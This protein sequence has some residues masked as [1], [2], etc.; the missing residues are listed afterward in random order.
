MNDTQAHH[1]RHTHRAISALLALSMLSAPQ[2][3]RASADVRQMPKRYTATVRG[4]MRLVGNTLL[5]CK[6]TPGY[7]ASCSGAQN[8]SGDG[9]N[10]K[11]NM[12]YVDVDGDPA[13]FNASRATLE[14]PNGAQ[15]AFAGLYWGGNLTAGIN[16]QSAPAPA[17]ATSVLLKAPGGAYVPISGVLVGTDETTG[18]SRTYAAFADVTALVRQSG[19]YWVGN[20]QAGTGVRDDAGASGGLFA[21]WGLVVVYR[22]NRLPLRSFNVWDAYFRVAE[23]T[24]G[25]VRVD[26]FITPLNGQF[27][28]QIGTIVFEGDRGLP[29]DSLRLESSLISNGLSSQ[30]N[31]FNGTVSAL[32]AEVPRFPAYVNQL[33]IDVDTFD[34]SAVLANGATTAQITLPTTADNYFPTMIAFAID[35]FEPRLEMSKTFV[36]VNGGAVNPG[37]TLRYTVMMTNTGVDA[38]TRVVLDDAIPANTTYLPGSLRV[39]ENPGSDTGAKT[40]ATGDDTA[41]FNAAGNRVAFRLG[42]G[43]NAQQGGWVAAGTRAAVE[44]CVT[45]NP[46]ASDGTTVLNTAVTTYSGSVISA[47]WSLTASASVDTIVRIPDLSIKISDGG[48]TTAPDGVIVYRITARNESGYTPAENVIV[49]NTLPTYTRY[50]GLETLWRQV[51]GTR[52]YTRSLGRMAQYDTRVLTFPVR[53]DATLPYSLTQLDAIARIGDASLPVPEPNLAN[54]VSTDQTPVE[55]ADIDALKSDALSSVRVGETVQYVFTVTN[56]GPGAAK[57]VRIHDPLYK[58]MLQPVWT[59]SAGPGSACGAAAGSGVISTTA[60]IAANSLVVYRL[61]VLVGSCDGLLINRASAFAP[62]IVDPNPANNIAIDV[63]NDGDGANLYSNATWAAITPGEATTL[64]LTVVN[65]GPDVASNVSMTAR[66]PAGMLLNSTVITGTPA[67][68]RFDAASGRWSIGTM[69]V[70]DAVTLT[71]GFAVTDTLAVGTV[72]TTVIDLDSPS[73]GNAPLRDYINAPV[74]AIVVVAGPQLTQYYLPLAVNR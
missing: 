34:A 36:D 71:L 55:Y 31:V 52:D 14:V 29:G 13:T 17:N 74:E 12:V 27:R 61:S 10:D 65:Y 57:A 68:T 16:G 6:Q 38:A 33:G 53:V 60:D 37:D 45:I 42:A 62:G 2:L 69:A 5:T 43:S 22:D 49:T 24:T 23:N 32:G 19:E 47:S 48:I 39:L 72:L 1:R 67:A 64:T 66:L 25:Q 30:S 15:V 63:D 44:F 3:T 58:G 35:V 4:D 56:R 59:C 51:P 40:D 73:V 41:E 50:T 28:A 8:G 26:D 7:A 20:V 18:Q 9:I 11:F 21:G 70:G 54:N 46:A